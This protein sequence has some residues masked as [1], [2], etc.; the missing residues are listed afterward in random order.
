MTY[1]AAIR[2]TFLNASTGR[3]V[4]GGTWQSGGDMD[5]VMTWGLILLGLFIGASFGYMVGAFFTRVKIDDEIEEAA[6]R[7]E[8]TARGWRE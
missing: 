5:P 4:C 7:A 3:N 6:W 1:G 2:W 8:M